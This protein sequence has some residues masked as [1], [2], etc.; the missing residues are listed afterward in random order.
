MGACGDG[1]TEATDPIESS[2]RVLLV[3]EGIRTGQKPHSWKL[4]IFGQNA[5]VTLQP[6]R[7]KTVVRDMPVSDRRRDPW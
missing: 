2:V 1:K 6:I 4:E 3:H 7:V 5:R